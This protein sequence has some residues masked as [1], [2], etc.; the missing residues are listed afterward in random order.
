VK[1]RMR[2]VLRWTNRARRYMGLRPIKRLPKGIVG[3]SF[4]CPIGT[5]LQKKI[6]VPASEGVE[7]QNH[8]MLPFEEDASIKLLT[9][10]AVD[11]FIEEFD[12]GNYP[13]LIRD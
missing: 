5:A 11:S 12:M 8:V 6:E 2:D 4:S 3:D 10:D 1:P 7:D 9:T 13:E